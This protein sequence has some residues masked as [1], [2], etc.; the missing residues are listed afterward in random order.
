M[1]LIDPDTY[2]LQLGPADVRRQAGSAAFGPMSAMSVLTLIPVVLFFFAF[3]RLLVEGVQTSG[4][5]G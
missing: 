1:Y 3:Q 5:K 2:T 4:L